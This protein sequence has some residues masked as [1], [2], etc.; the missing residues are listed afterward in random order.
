MMLGLMNIS[1]L[2]VKYSN[3]T[4]NTCHLESDLKNTLL[5]LNLI[6]INIYINHDRTNTVFTRKHNL[7]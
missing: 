1:I 3:V 6:T 7:V 5:S 4:T 2:C